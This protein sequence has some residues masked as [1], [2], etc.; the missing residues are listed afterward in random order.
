MFYITQLTGIINPL[1]PLSLKDIYLSSIRG[2]RNNIGI[3]PVL[4]IWGILAGIAIFLVILVIVPMWLMSVMIAT[5]ADEPKISDSLL[6]SGLFVALISLFMGILSA[7]TR[8]GILGWG[9]KVRKG[10]SAGMKDFFG[11]IFDFTWQLFLGGIFVWM[12]SM[13]PVLL[14]LNWFSTSFSDIMPQMFTSGWNY[15]HA[16]K[17]LSIILNAAFLTIIGQA[18]IFFW[19]A[20][21]DEMVALYRLRFHEALARSFFFVFSKQ[22]FGRVVSLIIVN[23][24]ISQ[25]LVVL[26]NIGTF[27]HLINH[28]FARAWIGAVVAAPGSNYTSIF[29]FLFM[30][31]FA[32]AQIY[33][34]PVP[35]TKNEIPVIPEYEPVI[36]LNQTF[37][38]PDVPDNQTV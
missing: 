6:I 17:F 33:L 5:G 2:I 18:V 7:A 14:L 20:P 11:G 10:K 22:N 26:T 27:Q 32:L 31:F 12:L 13:I 23:L 38:V 29:Q 34:L 4:F 19:I 9:V 25:I 15:V 37:P 35:E 24:I 28:G 36:K 16:L 30:P 1:M 21:W 8:A 3:Y